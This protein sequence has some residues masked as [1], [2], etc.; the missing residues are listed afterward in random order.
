MI[1]DRLHKLKELPLSNRSMVYL[2]W[3]YQVWAIISTIFINI[4]VFKLN[5]DILDVILYN[6]LWFFWIFIGFSWFWLI[7]SYLK[8]EIKNLYYL[9][10]IFSIISFIFIYIFNNL[11]YSIFIFAVIY[12]ISCWCFWV[13]LH[14]NE[15]SNINKDKRDFYSSSVSAWS[16]LLKII[17]PLFVSL[18]FFTWLYLNFDWYLALFF[19]LPFIYLISF[20]YLKNTWY[21]IPTKTN[22]SDLK[23]FLNFKKYKYANL[24][25]MFT[26]IHHAIVCV[27]LA[28][29]SITFLKNEINIWI[30]E[31]I[32]S[33]VSV[34][35][36]MFLA[37]KRNE[38]NRLIFMFYA[39]FLLSLNILI[40]VFNFSLIWY[41][42][43]SLIWIF[44]KPIYRVSEHV[45][46]LKIMD[47]IKQ[48]WA[49]FFPAMIIREL[50]LNVARI[51]FLIISFFILYYI[52]IDLVLTLKLFLTFQAF[53]LIM[54]RY[55]IYRFENDYN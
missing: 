35:A 21:Y 37:T 14:A 24:Y 52:K 15:L 53:I 45:F 28:V 50:V 54:I 9:S 2:M 31:A 3:I 20:I 41:I 55:S 5:N 33:L 51:W 27:I 38:N 13:S 19:I 12:G 10:Y 4:Y 32:M 1:I 34:F 30:Y 42:L 47:S 39:S 17:V 43:F 26:W 48:W 18:L 44:L 6:I 16:T 46:D 22:K 8:K 11:D 49:D 36:V 23:N 40:F 7:I 25:I 29:I